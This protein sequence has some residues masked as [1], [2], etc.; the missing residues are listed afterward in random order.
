MLGCTFS[1]LLDMVDLQYHVLGMDNGYE[2]IVSK[3][4]AK[5][6]DAH[7]EVTHLRSPRWPSSIGLTNDDNS[8][9]IK[10]KMRKMRFL[11]KLNVSSYI[12]CFWVL[13]PLLRAFYSSF[14]NLNLLFGAYYSHRRLFPHTPFTELLI[15]KQNAQKIIYQ[16]KNSE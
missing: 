11:Q 14:L 4:R 9:F 5:E 12:C 10:F 3:R 6:H 1:F 8:P 13:L 2:L 15:T 7:Y 16:V